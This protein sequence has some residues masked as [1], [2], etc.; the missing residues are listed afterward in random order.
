MQLSNFLIYFFAYILPASLML[1]FSFIIIARNRASVEHWLGFLLMNA[2][3]VLYMGEFIRH[4]LPSA[5]SGY[6]QTY[7]TTPCGIFILSLGLHFFAK[8]SNF[9]EVLKRPL[10]PFAFYVP[11]VLVVLSAFLSNP[12]ENVDQYIRNGPWIY[13]FYDRT[14]FITMI[15]SALLVIPYYFMLRSGKNRVHS[16]RDERL[17]VFMSRIVIAVF[18]LTLALGLPFL[19][20]ILPPKPFYYVG[21]L[22]G[23][24]IMYSMYRFDF[25][26]NNN[27]QYETI[28]ELTPS[29][30]LIFN[31]DWRV[32]EWNVAAESY[33]LY[34]DMSF[35]TILEM[36]GA[37]RY[38]SKLVT[39]FESGELI[40][41]FPVDVQMPATEELRYFLVDGKR[42]LK[43]RKFAYFFLV[44][45]VTEE[46]EAREKLK[47]IAFHDQLTGVANRGAFV[48]LS[49]TFIH[50]NPTRPAYF[51]LLDLDFFKAINDFYGHQ[52]GDEV[53]KKTAKLLEEFVGSFGRV[54]R[55][56]GD[57]FVFAILDN[58]TFPTIASIEN[59]LIAYFQVNALVVEDDVIPIV[60]SIGISR[61]PDEGRTYDDLYSLADLRM[62]KVKNERKIR[63]QNRQ[64]NA[65]R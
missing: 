20:G 1:A 36:Y 59:R 46:R 49:E 51:G 8:M 32:D 60:P 45:D 30:A 39:M 44:R 43:N 42:F 17:M 40:R 11:A 18:F 33:Q 62:Y 25:L 31:G 9:N 41:D 53:L 38:K 29:I 48:K 37:T 54:G 61:Y 13:I 2:Y 22:F 4:I 5:S 52:M 7:I 15:A 23:I 50:D 19:D 64:E 10:Y 28:F 21:I 27:D 63:R 3:T 34:Q 26:T 35:D 55:L 58:E 56:G 65:T 16:L 14:Y 24:G 57:E 12:H 47:F 6:I